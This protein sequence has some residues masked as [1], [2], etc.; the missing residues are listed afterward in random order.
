MFNSSCCHK[1]LLSLHCLI[2]A[3]SESDLLTSVIQREEKRN[4]LF[5]I[6]FSTVLCV[7]LPKAGKTSFCNLLMGKGTQVVS[8]GNTHTIYIKKSSPST[9]DKESKW[10]EINSDELLGIIHQLNHYKTSSLHV[11]NNKEQGIINDGEKWEVLLLLD[12]NIPSSAL[13]LLQPSVV[14]FVTYKMLGG[15]FSFDNPCAFIKSENKF[16]KFVKKI[17][18]SSCVT[19]ESKF[20]EL[21]I[22][23]ECGDT[24]TSYTVFVGI[25]NDSASSGSYEKEK[26]V[27]NRGLHAV[28]EHINCSS[29]EFPLSF[30]YEGKDTYL[31]LVN[32]AEQ[33]EQSIEN[34]RKGLDR[35]IAQNSAHKMPIIW[36]L[37]YFKL[38][39]L[40]FETKQ[41]Y[42]Y[43]SVVFEDLW[44]AGCNNYSENEFKL[45]LHFFHELGVL[46]YFDTVKGLK[47][48]IFIDCLWIFEKLN[49]LLSGFEDSKHDYVAKEV[50]K[51][52]G[53]LQSK[54][55]KQIKFEGPGNMK[56][57]TFV[58]LLKHLKYVAPLNQNDY[59]MPSILEVYKSSLDICKHYGSVQSTPLLVT[60]SSGSLHPSVFCYLAAYM[61]K[62][63]KWE[64]LK[65]KKQQHT[66][67]DLIIF[68]IGIEQYVCISDKTFF[69]EIRLHSNSKSNVNWHNSMYKFIQQA[70][71]VVCHNLQL[72]AKDCKYGFLCHSCEVG[73]EDHMMVVEEYKDNCAY[74]CKGNKT[75]KLSTSHIVWFEVRYVCML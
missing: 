28:K 58:N 50:L 23:D 61:M 49:Y 75:K 21:K 54:I 41:S 15:D 74:C 20:D 62:T 6:Q 44:K 43:Y 37:F 56:L 34:L 65:F 4:N 30:W 39:K 55:I 35:D 70:L 18:A 73:E 38:C 14:T 10:K 33:K 26:D 53:L 64:E 13:G 71:G 66:F 31:Y 72:S 60:F 25:M 1:W 11:K 7:G 68:S 63:N 48:Y 36:V 3:Q 46:F 8:S 51:H 27:I 16:P 32:L 52:E 57:Q 67:K 24:R 5:E 9:P 42:A 69:L 22:S 2:D 29:R 45:A 19:R 59:F 40:C 47:D 17:L 12:Y